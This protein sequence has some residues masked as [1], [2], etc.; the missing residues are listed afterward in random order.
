MEWCVHTVITPHKLS[1]WVHTGLPP[2]ILYI[3]R[4]SFTTLYYYIM[5]KTDNIYL[6]QKTYRLNAWLPILTESPIAIVN[7]CGNSLPL[8]AIPAAR[9]CFIYYLA[10]YIDSIPQIHTCMH[11]ENFNFKRLQYIQ[12]NF[13]F[14]KKG[15]L[16]QFEAKESKYGIIIINISQKYSSV[17][18]QT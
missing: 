16:A 7:L 14:M 9:F 15:L 5:H 3:S 13:D 18:D 6:P 4:F 8:G 2:Q 12:P 10:M 1:Q 17:Q 11:A